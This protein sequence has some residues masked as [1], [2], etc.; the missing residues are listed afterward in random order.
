MPLLVSLSLWR[1]SE[2]RSVSELES[3]PT[4]V[5][6]VSAAVRPH[7]YFCCYSVKYEINRKYVL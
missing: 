1:L 7:I 6:M 2:L 5:Q 3:E 4:R